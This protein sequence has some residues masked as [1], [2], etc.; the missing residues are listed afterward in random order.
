MSAQ[1]KWL[2]AAIRRKPQNQPSRWRK[3]RALQAK[4]QHGPG[5]NTGLG[6]ILAKLSPTCLESGVV[7]MSLIFRCLKKL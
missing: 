1:S 6:R 7:N 3:E 2:D 4:Q 5:A